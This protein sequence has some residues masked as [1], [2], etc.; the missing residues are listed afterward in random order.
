MQN[1]YVEQLTKVGKTSFA[2]LQKLGAI[3]TKALQKL[4]DLQFKYA[5]LNIETG[6]EQTKLL[7]STTNYKDYLSA[8]S[9]IAGEGS[10]Q[11]KEF[12]KQATPL[13]YNYFSGIDY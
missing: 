4:M 8:E 6:I 3:N 9:E 10:T 12:T 5:S 11:A 2:S 7:T 13:N 1:D